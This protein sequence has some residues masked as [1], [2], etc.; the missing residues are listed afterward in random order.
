MIKSATGFKLVSGPAPCAPRTAG[1]GRTASHISTMPTSA[2]LQRRRRR[3]VPVSLPRAC[4][5]PPSLA[6]EFAT[7]CDR[8]GSAV[9]VACRLRSSCDTVSH[10]ARYRESVESG[11]VVGLG[12]DRTGGVCR[13]GSPQRQRDGPDDSTSVRLP[14]HAADDCAGCDAMRAALF[15]AALAR[16]CAGRTRHAAQCQRQHDDTTWYSSMPHMHQCVAHSG[17]SVRRGQRAV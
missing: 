14:P 17:E 9:R 12:D 2:V 3:H 11:R 4:P 7:R 13:A 15:A 1:M 16:V 10:A 6:A 8:A 5:S